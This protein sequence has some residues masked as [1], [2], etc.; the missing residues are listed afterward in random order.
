[1]LGARGIAYAA[2]AFSLACCA[3]LH[4]DPLEEWQDRSIVPY[5][6]IAYGN[7]TFVVVGE[8]GLICASSNGTTWTTRPPFVETTLRGLVYSNGS[9]VA[10]GDA[11]I[12]ARSADGQIW[13]VVETELTDDLVAISY[14][15]GAF[16]A[17]GSGGVILTSSDG[18]TWT[19]QTS[20]TTSTLYAVAYGAAGFGAVG[21]NGTI[22]HSA[23]GTAWSAVTSG[24]DTLLDGVTFGG[25]KYAAVG[26]GGII[27]TSGDG[28]SWTSQTSGT[29][30]GLRAIQYLGGKFVAS[31]DRGR[32]LSSTDG[33][34]WTASLAGSTTNVHRAI[35]SDG[36]KQVIVGSAI[37]SYSNGPGWS[38]STNLPIGAPLLG[39]AS[40]GSQLVAVG[41]NSILVSADGGFVWEKKT[42]GAN[43]AGIKYQDG[44][45]LAMGS[46]ASRS[47]NG[48]TWTST[49]KPNFTVTGF[50]YGTGVWVAV[51]A[52]GS[53]SRSVDATTWQTSTVGLSVQ[54]NA[55]AFSNSNGL[56]V[57]VGT[58]GTIVTSADGVMWTRA[59]SVT[60]ETLYAVSEGSF[61]GM[62]VAGAK[63]TVITSWDGISWSVNSSKATEEDLY[64]L[65]SSFGQTVAVGSSGVVVT[66]VDSNPMLE[67]QTPGI[68]FRSVVFHGGKV[69]AVGDN[70]VIRIVGE[71]TV[72]PAVRSSPAAVLNSMA[73]FGGHVYAVGEGGWIAR[74]DDGSLWKTIDSGTT[75]PLK[76]AVSI[77]SA[78]Y[79]VG[80]YGGINGS[81]GAIL[82]TTDGNTWQEVETIPGKILYSVAGNGNTVVA[83]GA[84]GTIYTSVNAG[85]SWTVKSSGTNALLYDVMFKDGVFLAVGSSGTVFRSTDG[86]EWARMTSGTFSTLS[87]VTFSNAQFTAASNTDVI[88]SP[89][90]VTWTRSITTTLMDP[91]GKLLSGEGIFAVSSS[92]GPATSRDG[93]TWKRRAITNSGGAGRGIGFLGGRLYAMGTSGRLFCSS[94]ISGT[95]TLN[96]IVKDSTLGTPLSGATV[97]LGGYA[98]ATSDSNGRF[99]FSNLASGSYAL[100]VSRTGFTT[101]TGT[102]TVPTASPI[103]VLLLPDAA[104]SDNDG[105]SNYNEY[106]LGS[107]PNNPDTDADTMP[108]GWEVSEGSDLLRNDANEDRDKDGVSN[109]AEYS[110][111]TKPLTFDTD[112]DGLADGAEVALGTDALKTDTN[113]DGISD[114]AAYD[115]YGTSALL[116]DT[117]GD[118]MSD[119]Y[120]IAHGL[121]PLAD[122]RNLDRDFDFVTNWEEV[123]AGTSPS[124]PDSLGDGVSDYRRLHG[125]A[126]WEATYDRTDRLLG[127]RHENGATFAYRYDGN[128]NPVRQ[129]K[130][131]R[132]TDGDGLSDLAEFA[133]GMDPDSKSGAGNP[134]GDLDGDGWTNSQEVAAGTD[135]NDPLSTPSG[136]WSEKGTV[137]GAVQPSFTPT[138][139]VSATGQLDGVGPD[140]IVVAADGLPA[141]GTNAITVFTKGDSG[142]TI[143]SVDVGMF[144]VTS[145]AIGKPGGSDSAAI[146]L[147]LRTV[148]GTGSVVEVKKSGSVWSTK[149]LV[150]STDSVAFVLGLLNDSE[151]V[152]NLS[153]AG[154][155]PQAVYRLTYPS[156]LTL[157]SSESSTVGLGV[158]GGKLSQR[159]VGLRVKNSGGIEIVGGS[160]SVPANAIYSNT[161]GAYYFL[162]PTTLGWDAAEAYAVGAGGHLVTVNDI[163]KSNWLASQFP[164]VASFWIGLY[165]DAASDQTNPG[166]WKWIS[167]VPSSFTAMNQMPWMSGEPNNSGGIER[168]GELYTAQKTWNDA[169]AATLRNGLVEVSGFYASLPEVAAGSRLFS[170]G[171]V[172]AAGLLLTGPPT[173]GTEGL[174]ALYA[175]VDDINGS[176]Q[177]DIGDQFVLSEFG[178]TGTSA[179]LQKTY[180]VPMSQHA[181][182]V[183]YA[184]ATCKRTDNATDVLATGEP[185]GGVFLWQGSTAAGQLDRRLFSSHYTGS[186]WRDLAAYHGTENGD[187]LIGLNVDPSTLSTCQVIYWPS[188]SIGTFLSNPVTQSAPKTRVLG[189]TFKGGAHSLVKLKVWDMEGNP[190]HPV[191]QWQNPATGVWQNAS[192]LKLDQEAYSETSYAST[193]KEGTEHVILWD[194]LGDLGAT[195]SGQTFLRVRSEER[196]IVGPWSEILPFSVDNTGDFDGDGF[197]DQW[198]IANNLDPNVG[199]SFLVD[200]DADGMP[201]LLEYAFGKN[202]KIPES[203]GIALNISAG[204]LQISFLCNTACTGI[205]YTV[206]SSSTLAADSWTDIAKSVGGAAT[207]PVE[208]LSTVS[209]SATGLRTVTVTDSAPIAAGGRRFLR[210]KV[211]SP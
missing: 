208:T 65:A 73:S 62:V 15:S 24:T 163:T 37:V 75:V 199:N 13:T 76:K 128:G 91:G 36:T 187:G 180:R 192:V 21:P 168:W 12:I 106:R 46:G 170:K 166:S 34:T 92:S 5:N 183:F 96:G 139:F 107:S 67:E 114:G 74:A 81:F 193:S 16:V 174:S 198:E 32:Y 66:N 27:L 79:A 2:L 120:E 25:G 155:N 113:G 196:T 207:V 93:L 154:N 134:E 4:A 19:E 85:E 156:T 151:L 160:G 77:S 56:F 50:A 52:N 201:G 29:T 141:S 167:G 63:G 118:G 78:L 90:G 89:D 161:Y 190:S 126:K 123:Q 179:T 173:T 68:V 210:V 197:S 80:G 102:P 3:Y 205:T 152:V 178:V 28:I 33:Q 171:K 41:T 194:T 150:S 94:P 111:G 8:A 20:P 144:G 97:Q 11:G 169:S 132:D 130:L 200:E 54:L 61:G 186:T 181:S 143:E 95:E 53:C 110:L 177:A 30:D 23:D 108:D 64:G 31:G 35:A 72:V 127:V 162:T 71:K 87:G 185:D 60:T 164:S 135:P 172:T 26:D 147:G 83:V 176:G 206:Q 109:V 48:T 42:G 133:N 101:W 137:L 149:T 84:M 82:R 10:V 138:N 119:A 69:I 98:S 7:S 117:D 146:Y 125:E 165:R 112:G 124:L 45:F 103:E 157:L 148:T 121:N 49:T 1:M 40:N 44:N 47:T 202:P 188:E 195:F 116:T 86:N 203:S 191:L 88:F 136:E 104:D 158:I 55:I 142:W 131:G 115:Q 99:S 159:N 129:I 204:N 209:D 100:T 14:G 105:L 189:A 6:A 211:T 18:V 51:G 9:F 122:D 140:E 38:T 58:G 43:Y 153:K 22:L 39:I 59:T 145:I 57:A 70:G 184:L 17:V 175:F 182:G